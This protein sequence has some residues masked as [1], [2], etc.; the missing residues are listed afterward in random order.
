[1]SN[2][3]SG[4]PFIPPTSQ[5]APNP[6]LCERLQPSFD[7][8]AN[9][10]PRTRD[11][12]LGSILVPTAPAACTWPPS[13]PLMEPPPPGF[14]PSRIPTRHTPVQIFPIYTLRTRLS[15]RRPVEASVCAVSLRGGPII[16]PSSD[17]VVSPYG[18]SLHPLIL[19][20]VLCLSPHVAVDRL[21]F[22]HQALVKVLLMHALPPAEC[23]RV[24]YHVRARLPRCAQQKKYVEYATPPSL[25]R[26]SLGLSCP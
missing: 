24:C 15:P 22:P 3:S 17:I 10:C 7:E 12:R 26:L 6:R 20:Y 14:L 13:L 8:V 11:P 2:F 1:M 16:L 19:V 23:V 18:D 25:P 4:R 5:Q 9:G 21:P